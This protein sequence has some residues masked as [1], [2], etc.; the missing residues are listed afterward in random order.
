[1]RNLRNKIQRFL[2]VVLATLTLIVVAST[3]TLA[4][5]GATPTPTP[6]PEVGLDAG[7]ASVAVTVN[8]RP[9]AQFFAQS[10]TSVWEGPG[11][12]MVTAQLPSGAGVFIIQWTADGSWANISDGTNPL[13]WV[14]ASVLSSTP[15][16]S[17]NPSTSTVTMPDSSTLAVGTRAP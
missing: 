16:R 15:P 11:I 13:G 6:L 8:V 4:D 12:G 9:N 14:L 17:G 10:T 1:M 5:G 7:T 2:L 3:V